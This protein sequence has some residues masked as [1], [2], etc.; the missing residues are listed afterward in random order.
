MG[1]RPASNALATIPD[2]HSLVRYERMVTAIAECH[3]VDEVSEIHSKARALE[4]YAQQA[5]NVDA[6]R[7][8]TEIRLRAERR[9]GE[10]LKEL[11][12]SPQSK[13]GRIS[14]SNDATPKSEFSEALDRT[15]I[16]RQTASR[17]QALAAVPEPAFERHLK[18]PETK[19]TTSG[20]LR[21]ANGAVRMD[22]CSLRVWGVLRDFER[23]GR[24]DR[25]V[26]DVFGGMTN[27]MQADVRRVL[28]AIIHWL[29][30]LHEVS[31]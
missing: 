23:D 15:G 14:A 6:E 21:A 13:G 16:T 10:L 7:K 12:R 30:E 24:M 11:Q 2:L 29:N 28:P 25:D 18:A 22:D 31:R 17:Y 19:P 3:S 9:T 1:P 27:T 5:K 8:A 4:I 26:A 20:I